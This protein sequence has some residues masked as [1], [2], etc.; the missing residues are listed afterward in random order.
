MKP[1]TKYRGKYPTRVKEVWGSIEQGTRIKTNDGTIYKVA[2]LPGS[3]RKS[4][5]LGEEL[6]AIECR[7]FVTRE[8]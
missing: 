1:K 4:I 5:E 8:K 2:P 7:C 3:M 6:C